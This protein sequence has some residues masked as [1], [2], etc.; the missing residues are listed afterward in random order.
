L[1]CSYVSEVAI[2]ELVVQVEKRV[3]QIHATL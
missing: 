3:R 1:L 2:T